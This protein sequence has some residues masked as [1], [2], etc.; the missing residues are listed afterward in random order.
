MKSDRTLRECREWMWRQ[1]HPNESQRRRGHWGQAGR[2]FW[3]ILERAGRRGRRCWGAFFFLRCDEAGRRRQVSRGLRKILSLLPCRR[4]TI[5]SG[6][7]VLRLP[8]SDSHFLVSDHTPRSDSVSAPC[9]L[10]SSL[11][12]APSC[13]RRPPMA[14]S[15]SSHS[16]GSWFLSTATNG[17]PQRAREPTF[18]IIFSLLPAAIR[19]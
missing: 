13:D 8:F 9:L 1:S 10:P 11:S 5:L 4:Q 12:F 19:T 17:L 2:R 16:S 6:A 7:A 14:T 15:L 3:A 18:L